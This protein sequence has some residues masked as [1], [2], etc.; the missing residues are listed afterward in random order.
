MQMMSMKVWRP[1]GS[2]VSVRSI[3]SSEDH[4]GNMVAEGEMTP[5]DYFAAL[6]KDQKRRAVRAEADWLAVRTDREANDYA[7]DWT[8]RYMDDFAR[9]DA[10]GCGEA[11]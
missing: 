9:L 1:D 11:R 3:A 5:D 10:A 8:R 4:F 7:A 6:Y 2:I